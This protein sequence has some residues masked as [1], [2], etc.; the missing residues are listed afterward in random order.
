MTAYR[1][2]PGQAAV[3]VRLPGLLGKARV[4]GYTPPIHLTSSANVALKID[5]LVKAEIGAHPN[6]SATLLILFDDPVTRSKATIRAVTGNPFVADTGHALTRRALAIAALRH[7]RDSTFTGESTLVTVNYQATVLHH[8]WLV[9]ALLVHMP[10]NKVN[11]L[12]HESSV[13]SIEPEWGS[14]P[15]QSATCGYPLTH[16]DTAWQLTGVGAYRRFRGGNIALLDTGVFP[17]HQLLTGVFSGFYDCVTDETVCTQTDTQSDTYNDPSGHGTQSAAILAA[18]PPAGSNAGDRG[19]TSA[20][21]AS[22]LVY[23]TNPRTG[24]YDVNP[25]STVTAIQDALV[26]NHDII[27]AVIAHNK[28]TYGTLTAKVNLAY[29]LGAVVVAS[30]GNTHLPTVPSIPEPANA[31]R[32][33]G[34]GMYCVQTPDAFRSDATWGPTVDGR[35]KPDV[36]GLTEIYTAAKQS[37]ISMNSFGGTSGAAPFVGGIS[38]ILKNWMESGGGVVT[39]GHV[40]AMLEMCGS[41]DSVDDMEG[42]G[43]I[44]LPQDGYVWW[45]ERDVA[46]DDDLTIK[47]DPDF[48]GSALDAA[49]W[50]PEYGTADRGFPSGEERAWITLDGRAPGGTTKTSLKQGTVFQKVHLTI[51]RHGGQ[52][53]ITIHG[54]HVPDGAREV[55]FAAWVH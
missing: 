15:P 29:D 31:P 36:G 34:V 47:L 23:G 17:R 51:P 4:P 38:R 20:D 42:A 46:E 41:K 54:A 5:S 40:Y 14:P 50:W 22:Y 35:I 25:P 26:R 11:A 3:Q 28:F 55:Y 8:Y 12:A 6:D 7:I 18:N 53:R 21:L 19:L 32:A 30:N 52:W 2:G 9:P 10:L 1:A 45:G 33:I 49:I 27:V 44:L 24:V 16:M 37:A 48:H 13:V 39:P 43:R